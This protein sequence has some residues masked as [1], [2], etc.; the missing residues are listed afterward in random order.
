M[1]VLDPPQLLVDGLLFLYVIALAQAAVHASDGQVVLG[2]GVEHAE[3]LGIRAGVLGRS[4][5]SRSTR[6]C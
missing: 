5:P 3:Y 4:C 6:L 1:L 2:V